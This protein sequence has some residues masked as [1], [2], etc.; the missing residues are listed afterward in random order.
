MSDQPA[1]RKPRKRI[2]YALGASLIASGMSYDQAAPKCGAKT[3]HSLQVGLH[4]R[5][6][7][8]TTLRQPMA[9][10]ASGSRAL[11]RISNLVRSNLGDA[12]LSQSAAAPLLPATPVAKVLRA[13]GDA[14]AA[15]AGPAAKVFGW[16]T[17]TANVLVQ[18][19]AVDTDPILDVDC[20]QP[21]PQ[22]ADSPS[23]PDTVD[24]MS[25]ESPSQAD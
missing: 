5:G 20:V 10:V 18:V 21:Q 8:Q 11:M 25:P 12:L 9:E 17:A 3:G 6:L 13:N 7:T 16:D 2:N 24:T 19:R 15:I 4:E 22:L 14:I 23:H 1:L